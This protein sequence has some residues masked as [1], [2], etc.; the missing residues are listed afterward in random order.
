MSTVYIFDTRIKVFQTKNCMLI[1]EL[2]RINNV[3][4]MSMGYETHTSLCM[5]WYE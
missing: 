3:L 2:A 1:N 5:L 4:L